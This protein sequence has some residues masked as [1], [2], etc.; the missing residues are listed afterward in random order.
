M[1]LFTSAGDKW[2]NIIVPKCYSTV[3]RYLNVTNVLQ[4]LVLC[5]SNSGHAWL[6]FQLHKGHRAMPFIFCV[7]MGTAVLL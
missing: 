4:A 1:S 6:H 7:L 5:T 2:E 3:F